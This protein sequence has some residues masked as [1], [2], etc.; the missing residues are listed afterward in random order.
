M[1][2][3]KVGAWVFLGGGLGSVLRFGISRLQMPFLPEQFPAGTVLAN[4]LAC[5]LLGFLILVLKDRPVAND[6]LKYFLAIGFCGG[7]STFSTFG[8]ETVQLIK[9]GYLFLA[10]LNIVI[11][12]GIGFTILWLFMRA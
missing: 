3:F 4:I 10:I 6:G 12:I 11:S 2:I 9:T 7:F 8:F 1:E 5:T